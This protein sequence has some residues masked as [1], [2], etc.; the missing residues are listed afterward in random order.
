MDFIVLECGYIW[1][2]VPPTG[3]NIVLKDIYK[4][5]IAINCEEIHYM[6]IDTIKW[7]D[8]VPGVKE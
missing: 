6:V 1:E 7:D 4:D 8:F 3:G 2:L 5:I